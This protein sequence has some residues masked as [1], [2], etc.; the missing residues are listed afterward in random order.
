MNRQAT[1]TQPSA[2]TDAVRWPTQ[3]GLLVAWGY[4]AHQ[5]GLIEGLLQV[6]VPQKQ[7]HHAPQKKLLEFQ[8]AI[9]AGVEYLQDINVGPHPLIRDQA[10]PL[11]WGQERLAHYSAVSRT[12]ETCAPETVTAVQAVLAAVSQP[13]IQQIV[14][15]CLLGTGCLTLDLDL[16][17]RAVSNTSQSY[18]EAAFGWMGDAVGLGYQ[19]AQVSTLTA[20]YGRQ[21]L[22]G[23]HHP[24]NTVSMACLQELILAAEQRLGLRPRRRVELLE[25]QLRHLT[26]QLALVE[27]Q[28]QKGAITLIF[29][30]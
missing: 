10:V 28:I 26:E 23:F 4:F 22:A 13:F 8:M 1:L 17:G 20:R 6:P 2:E 18:P 21:W 25:P 11:A 16:M 5:I 30:P 14:D 19:L 27:V 7:V 15:D 3:H 12:L 29:S 9:L 24:G